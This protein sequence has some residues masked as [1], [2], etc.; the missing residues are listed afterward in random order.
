M[1]DG[2]RRNVWAS[3]LFSHFQVPIVPTPM[4]FGTGTIW[5]GVGV[6]L[7]RA[8]LDMR[9]LNTHLVGQRR[10]PNS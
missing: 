7:F 3:P 6:T 9:S 10:S 2:S 4:T 8:T 5:A 1:V